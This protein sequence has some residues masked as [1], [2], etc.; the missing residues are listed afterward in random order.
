MLRKGGA[1]TAGETS[2]CSSINAGM[3]RNRRQ[4]RPWRSACIFVDKRHRRR[5]L[6]RFLS[7]GTFELFEDFGFTRIRQVGKHAWIVS[8]TVAAA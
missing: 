2:S 4:Y 8:K 7:S 1:S 3:R 5:A 6:D